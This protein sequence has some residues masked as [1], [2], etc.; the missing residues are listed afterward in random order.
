MYLIWNS[1]MRWNLWSSLVSSAMKDRLIWAMWF[2][3]P[4]YCC[5]KLWKTRIRLLMVVLSIRFQIS[6]VWS[7]KGRSSADLLRA[8]LSSIFNLSCGVNPH[9]YK[10]SCL[11][12]AYYSLSCWAFFSYSYLRLA[13]CFCFSFRSRTYFNLASTAPSNCSFSQLP[14]IYCQQRC[15]TS[16]VDPNSVPNISNQLS[17]LFLF[18][19]LKWL[20]M[21]RAD[22]FSPS[23]KL[24]GSI[25]SLTCT[26]FPSIHLLPSMR[27][28]AF[29]G[30]TSIHQTKSTPHS[31]TCLGMTLASLDFT[32]R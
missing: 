21:A 25:S 10:V 11:F 3:F 7:M 1:L 22:A 28:N 4:N 20:R 19:N 30:V 26:S 13:H 31:R 29:Y 5:Y 9:F 15:E 24:Y 27:S 23:R 18:F 2:L 32:N 16:S 12:L 6:A 17:S 14:S 8:S